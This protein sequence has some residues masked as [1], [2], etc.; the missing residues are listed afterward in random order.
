LAKNPDAVNLWIGNSKSVTATHRDN[1]ENI[2]VQIIGSKHFVL[3]PALCHPCMNE[4]F[5]PPATYS[6]DV[7]GGGGLRLQLDQDAEPVPFATWDPDSPAANATPLSHLARPVR[8]T[9]RPGDMLY[10]PATWLGRL[11]RVRRV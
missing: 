2:Y 7:P 3:L 4:Q 5:L 11:S 8:V 10:L 9:L 6:R 1:Y